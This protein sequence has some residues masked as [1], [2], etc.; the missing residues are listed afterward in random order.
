MSKPRKIGLILVAILVLVFFSYLT[1]LFLKLAWFLI[2]SAILIAGYFFSP[3]IAVKP[4]KISYNEKNKIKKEL[5]E[6]LKKY[7]FLADDFKINRNPLVFKSRKCCQ[8][9]Q[10]KWIVWCI[11]GVVIMAF[12]SGWVASLTWSL[13]TLLLLYVDVSKE[14]K[15]VSKKNIA[16]EFFNSL[17]ERK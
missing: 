16:K 10:K 8:K 11:V 17:S 4:L 15:E 9:L 1:L 3:I 7:S 12:L 14:R 2:P 13:G 5:Q 6:C